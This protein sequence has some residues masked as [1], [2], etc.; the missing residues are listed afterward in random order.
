M[1]QYVEDPVLLQDHT[2]SQNAPPNDELFRI[3]QP[4]LGPI[5]SSQYVVPSTTEFFSDD[6]LHE[7]NAN[8]ENSDNSSGGRKTNNSVKSRYMGNF[9]AFA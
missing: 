2:V 3:T 8:D 1:I 4:T 5:H 6:S 9:L 7:Q